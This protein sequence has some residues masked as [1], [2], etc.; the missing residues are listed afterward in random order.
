MALQVPRNTQIEYALPGARPAPASVIRR[1]GPPAD[2]AGVGGTSFIW[3]LNREEVIEWQEDPRSIPSEVGQK[4]MLLLQAGSVINPDPRHQLIRLPF[5]RNPTVIAGQLDSNI[6]EA[7]IPGAAD[8]SLQ[9]LGAKGETFDLTVL[10][11]NAW[12][13]EDEVPAHRALDALREIMRSGWEYRVFWYPGSDTQ[14]IPVV[15]QSVSYTAE[16][17][18]PHKIPEGHPNPPRFKGNPFVSFVPSGRD[19][20]PVGLPA[21]APQRVTATLKLR[22]ADP[23]GALVSPFKTDRPVEKPAAKRTKGATLSGE[24][25]RQW[26]NLVGR[27]LRELAPPVI[28]TYLSAATGVNAFLAA[29]AANSLLDQAA[30]ALP[31]IARDIASA[32]SIDTAKVQAQALEAEAQRLANRWVERIQERR[33]FDQAVDAAIRGTLGDYTSPQSESSFDKYET[34]TY[35][36]ARRTRSDAS[37]RRGSTQQSGGD[38]RSARADGARGYARSS[39]RTVAISADQATADIA[40]AVTTLTATLPGVEQE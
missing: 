21:D 5:S 24:P 17:F 10:F 7:V 37:F 18:T 35:D 25:L 3:Q 31:V 34:E 36:D 13:H 30:R 40:A 23:S 33:A 27:E 19:V 26:G 6:P 20:Y 2:T 12:L 16:N 22:R 9:H 28:G 32:P 1:R 29:R 11:D 8:V 38:A 15:I 14:F 4:G 39:R